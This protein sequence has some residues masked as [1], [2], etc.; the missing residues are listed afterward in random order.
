MAGDADAEARVAALKNLH[1]WS[2][3]AAFDLAKAALEDHQPMVRR[4]A[5][6]A[7]GHIDD[8][9][10]ADTVVGALGDDD[11]SVREALAA[12]IDA[13]GL[14]ALAPT[15][16]AIRDTDLE[17]GALLSDY[18]GDEG[19]VLTRIALLHEEM[20]D[21][22]QALEFHFRRVDKALQEHEAA[23]GWFASVDV[24]ECTAK[25]NGRAGFH[26]DADGDGEYLLH[27]LRSTANGT[28]GVWISSETQAGQVVLSSC[29][30]AGNLGAGARASLGNKPILA[31]HCVFAGNLEAGLV[32]SFT[33]SAAASR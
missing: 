9:R 25:N 8:P 16:D 27:R 32:S 13:I 31:S 26:V 29:Y 22:A 10:C 30:L 18:R 21:L 14:P 17:D 3:E 28:D 33:A 6:E 15:V 12:S 1:T 4:A 2:S 7:L 23:P 19:L 11:G 20:G 5:A 24:R